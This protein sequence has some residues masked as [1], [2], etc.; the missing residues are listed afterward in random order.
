MIIYDV[1]VLALNKQIPA[2]KVLPIFFIALIKQALIAH[3]ILYGFY[4]IC[5]I[6]KR[7]SIR[8]TFSE[9]YLS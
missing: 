8:K 1:V 2:G 7:K 3:R 6:A 5:N 9:F 4:K